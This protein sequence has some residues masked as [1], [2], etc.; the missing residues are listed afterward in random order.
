MIAS[1][2]ALP[3]TAEELD[4]LGGTFRVFVRR[5]KDHPKAINRQAGAIEVMSTPPFRWGTIEQ[6]RGLWEARAVGRRVNNFTLLPIF[7]HRT[8]SDCANASMLRPSQG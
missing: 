3:V 1:S 2:A 5:L 7:D 8:C 6:S 4:E